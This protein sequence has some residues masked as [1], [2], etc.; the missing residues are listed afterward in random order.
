MTSYL[1]FV[2][3]VFRQPNKNITNGTVNA[4]MTAQTHGKMFFQYINDVYDTNNSHNPLCKCAELRIELTVPFAEKDA[5]KVIGA[6]WD[7]NKRAWYT[8][9][10]SNEL[11]SL[12]RWCRESD[13]HYLTYPEKAREYAIARG[14]VVASDNRLFVPNWF[15]LKGSGNRLCYW[16]PNDH[17]EFQSFKTVP[18][19]ALWLMTNGGDM[20]IDQYL[21]EEREYLQRRVSSGNGVGGIYIYEDKNF[22]YFRHSSWD[23]Y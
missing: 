8:T 14:A 22:S 11:K 15:W 10:Q 4:R 5:A 12:A 1:P 18:E 20:P 9:G 17:S 19:A 23:S 16:L 2:S 7:A 6:K 3:E 21:P 13:R